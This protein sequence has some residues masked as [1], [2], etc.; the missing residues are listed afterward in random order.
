[1]S[2]EIAELANGQLRTWGDAEWITLHVR[3]GGAET[4]TS[5]THADAA[6]LAGTLLHLVGEDPNPLGGLVAEIE[7]LRKALDDALTPMGGGQ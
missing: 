7:R 4:T 5:L 1:M 6:A 3:S 2:I